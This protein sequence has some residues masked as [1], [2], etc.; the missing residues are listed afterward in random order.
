MTNREDGPLR[1][2]ATMKCGPHHIFPWKPLQH[3]LGSGHSG[4]RTA[5]RPG[6]THS[7]DTENADAHTCAD[8]RLGSHPTQVHGLDEPT[9]DISAPPDARHGAREQLRRSDGTRASGGMV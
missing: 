4:E 3:G 5:E 8:C 9:S 1:I 6:G 2:G 7:G